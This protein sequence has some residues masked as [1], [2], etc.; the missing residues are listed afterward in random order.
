[1]WSY[2]AVVRIPAIKLFGCDVS[3]L[4]IKVVISAVIREGLV[5]TG[6]RECD[7]R[8]LRRLGVWRTQLVRCAATRWWVSKDR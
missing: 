7:M 3:I 2:I 8:K 1:M 4:L 5:M 6:M